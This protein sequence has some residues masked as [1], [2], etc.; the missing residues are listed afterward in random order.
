MKPGVSRLLSIRYPPELATVFEFASVADLTAHFSIERRGVENNGGFVFDAD[1]FDDLRG[2]FEFVVA[3]E[4][5]R[6]GGLDLGKFD[7]FFLLRRSGTGLLLLHELV[8]A[9]YVDGQPTLT[10]HQFGEVER[11]ALL[12]IEAK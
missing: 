6:G 12:V 5:G 1:D 10:G 7:N 8:E 2:R 4:A 9:G 11:K 3:D